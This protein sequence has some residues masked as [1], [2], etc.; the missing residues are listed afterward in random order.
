MWNVKTKVVVGAL[1]TLRKDIAKGMELMS[2]CP[3]VSEIQK[4]SQFGHLVIHPS[5]ARKP[6]GIM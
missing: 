4:I 1:G 2:G 3:K 6:R 5:L